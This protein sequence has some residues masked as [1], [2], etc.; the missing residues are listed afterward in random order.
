MRPFLD[1]GYSLLDPPAAGVKHERRGAWILGGRETR[2]LLRETGFEG[3]WNAAGC[4]G[5]FFFHFEGSTVLSGMD[6]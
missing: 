6:R 5:S 4:H 1:G 2:S 3:F